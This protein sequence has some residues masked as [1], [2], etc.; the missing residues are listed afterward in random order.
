MRMY[1]NSLA[2]QAVVERLSNRANNENINSTLSTASMSPTSRS[3]T[4][5]FH[6]STLMSLYGGDQEFVKEVVEA[7]RSLLSTVVEG[8]LPSEY[9]K[10]C[11]IRTYFRIISG[12]MF[13]LKVSSPLFKPKPLL[14]LESDICTWSQRRRSCYIPQPHGQHSECS[15]NLCCR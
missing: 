3:M 9:L 6:P 8:L 4:G 12:A 5:N 1:I 2:L 10:H 13:L 14:N 15:S 11:P 7:S